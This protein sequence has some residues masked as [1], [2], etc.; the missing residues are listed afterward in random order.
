MDDGVASAAARQDRDLRSV[1]LRARAGLH[2]LLLQLRFH[3]RPGLAW[4]LLRIE[5]MV[6]VV[7]AIAALCSMSAFVPQAWRIVKTRKTSD[8]S[9]VMWT[10]QV[11]GFAVWIAYGA[12]L[13]AWPIVFQNAVCVALA[14]FI[15]VM[16]VLPRHMRHAVADRIDPE[17]R[18]PRGA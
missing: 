7:G 18:S 13:G 9:A 2:G 12:M 8:L 1:V 3:L 10:L 4:C 11:I 6:L 17:V 16:K 5:R 15:L 14:G